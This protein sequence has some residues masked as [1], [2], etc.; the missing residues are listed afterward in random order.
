VTGVELRA[1][2]LAPL[3]AALLLLAAL[4]PFQVAADPLAL[5]VQP[6]ALALCPPSYG[7]YQLD[8]TG[9]A[10]PAALVVSG[11][12]S[13]LIA[14]LFPVN[15][16]PPDSSYLAVGRTDAVTPGSF[17]LTLTATSASENAQEIVELSIPAGLPGMVALESPQDNKNL[18]N[19]DAPLSWTAD[20]AASIYRVEVAEDEAMTIL[21]QSAE[22][23]TNSH[24]ALGLDSFTSYFWRV[25]A[26]N[27]C[28]DGTPSTI[29]Q[30]MT[31][32]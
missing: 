10:S 22:V 26:R 27:A 3:A 24:T 15:V 12:P 20:P 16:T 32:L 28:G 14:N 23:A 5:D 11:V 18:V 9:P 31:G 21:V 30:F 25:T 8:V 29:F 17:N 2:V 4:A 13:G 7:L 6:V 19:P 1:R